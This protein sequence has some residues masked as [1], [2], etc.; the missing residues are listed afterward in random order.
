ML[1]PTEVLDPE[2]HAPV[3]SLHRE[4][5]ID[6]K[7]QF[8]HANGV[9]PPV[10]EVV[11]LVEVNL[12]GKEI[13][14]NPGMSAFHNIVRMEKGIGMGD[15]SDKSVATG[16]SSSW[17]DMEYWIG[18]AV[19]LAERAAR[20]GGE[21]GPSEEG[22]FR[23]FGLQ[24]GAPPNWYLPAG[25][26]RVPSPRRIPERAFRWFRA[27]IERL[28]DP[29]KWDVGYPPDTQHAA[30]TW[31]T[32][33]Q[34]L[35]LH[36]LMGRVALL[37][38][39]CLP[40]MGEIGPLYQWHHGLASTTASRAGPIKKFI[41]IFHWHEGKLYHIANMKGTCT[42]RRLVH[43]VSSFMNAAT[44]AYMTQAKSGLKRLAMFRHGDF[45][46]KA[47]RLMEALRRIALLNK[48]KLEDIIRTS[49]DYA[50]F[51]TTVAREL[52]ETFRDLV[53]IP[54]YGPK[55][56]ACWTETFDLSS[57]SAHPGFSEVAA[58]LISR[59]GG[60]VSGDGWTSL[61]GTLI[62]VCVHLESIAEGYGIDFTSLMEAIEEGY[63]WVE[64]WGDDETMLLPPIL[65]FRG[66]GYVWREDVYLN[67]V[68]L[69]GLKA[70][71][72]PGNEHLM[73][74]Y[75][76]VDRG[77]V[78]TMLQSRY[79]ARVYQQT[80]CPERGNKALATQL[81][82]LNSRTAGVEFSPLWPFTE[83]LLFGQQNAVLELLGNGPYS[84]GLLRR[85]FADPV[86]K[87]W[88]LEQMPNDERLFIA[89]E[90]VSRDAPLD[91]D[92]AV[93]WDQ[94]Q[95]RIRKAQLRIAHMS[96]SEALRQAVKL[97]QHLSTP[98]TAREELDLWMLN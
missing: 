18:G 3:G 75:A 51:D 87:N 45:N 50:G 35:M 23:K 59:F 25:S 56:G 20:I 30:P 24:A 66:N 94:S 5:I 83:R 8:P 1:V 80:I 74:R 4:W 67:A 55:V 52:E 14:L 2:G 48:V 44:Y 32:S 16:W 47:W 43:M 26:T 79:A 92:L 42:R 21:W 88:I 19:S 54:L 6:L 77:G 57:L 93:Y 85:R 68:S 34:D 63:L 71:V 9:E 89:R 7:R 28:Q 46:Q 84:L 29:L 11:K 49:A 72:E 13:P 62:A 78:R 22:H 90:L 27:Q 37:D 86:F 98:K 70:T 12:P 33:H 69:Y 81:W 31:S 91:P 36:F 38:G 73:H 40:V 39:S 82:G 15:P 60:I 58:W 97:A 76:L 96:R 61:A 65:R 95:D 64:E 17:D 41:P 53:I 10:I